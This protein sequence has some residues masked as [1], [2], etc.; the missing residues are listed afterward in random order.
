MGQAIIIILKIRT[1]F[2]LLSAAPTKPKLLV[3]RVFLF[4]GAGRR[5]ESFSMRMI[6]PMPWFT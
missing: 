2:L 3:P 4:G 1:L 5:G 6:A